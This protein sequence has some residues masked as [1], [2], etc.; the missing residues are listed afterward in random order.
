MV[1]GNSSVLIVQ[2]LYQFTLQKVIQKIIYDEWLLQSMLQ[3]DN[4][5][6]HKK[7]IPHKQML[8]QDWSLMC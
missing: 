5:F 7:V 4:A 8:F 3:G 6:P 2:R 1:N